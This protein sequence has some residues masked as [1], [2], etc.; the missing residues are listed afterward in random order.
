MVPD[1]Q[2]S[3]LPSELSGE[4]LRDIVVVL[5]ILAAG[6]L[7]FVFDSVPVF[8]LAALLV[9]L[10]AQLFGMLPQSSYDGPGTVTIA[11]FF[12][13]IGVLVVF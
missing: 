3:I 5:G 6:S 7:L 8:L 1:T 12:V 9:A 11:L 13:A 4:P 2:A 10:L